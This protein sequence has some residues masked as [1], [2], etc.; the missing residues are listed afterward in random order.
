[1][2]KCLVQSNIG[3]FS[4]SIQSIRN[5]S[6]FKGSFE[7]GKSIPKDDNV[8]NILYLNA[9]HG[10]QSLVGFGAKT[11]LDN[12]KS[13][14]RVNEV[15]LWKDEL[16]NYQLAH[17]LAKLRILNSQGSDEDKKLFEPVLREAEMINSVDLVLIASP[18]WNYSVPYV[19][20]Q[21]IDTVVQPGINFFEDEPEP[22]QKDG[23]VQHGNIEGRTVLVISSAGAVYSPG[24]QL[25]D[26][27]NPFLKQIFAL[28]GF[29]EFRNI[30]I[31]N[32]MSAPK[33]ESLDWTK[34]QA[35]M[36]AHQV[37][38]MYKEGG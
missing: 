3:R 17:A 28:M 37:S 33:Q 35:L 22:S 13:E 14:H 2:L 5:N 7:R 32:T 25:Q 23:V 1:M 20:K 30:F 27:L 34:E 9:S 31:Q 24:G 4:T 10:P 15:N 21:Y 6:M 29:T 38:Q 19:L 11:F 26:F 18:M 8:K 36:H 16:V 12:L